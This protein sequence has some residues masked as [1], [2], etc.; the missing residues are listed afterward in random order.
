LIVTQVID[1]LR[2]D[3]VARV[4]NDA[5]LQNLTHATGQLADRL[6]D[7]ATD[8]VIRRRIPRL[9]AVSK[10]PLAW[11][12]LFRQL[13]DTNAEIR[14]RCGRALFDIAERH[15]EFRPSEETVFLLFERELIAARTP[16]AFTH[17][18]NVLSLVLPPHSVQLAFRALQSG[19]P[20]LR[21]T[22]IEYLDSVLPQS[23]R[24]QLGAQFE[25]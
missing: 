19:D 10:N 11:D 13:S 8:A 17:M 23:L 12:V 5:L 14:H 20:K 22:A 25:S 9:L 7:P 1:L 24:E 4:A 21:A 16:H 6:A 3:D 15:P 18:A 2:R